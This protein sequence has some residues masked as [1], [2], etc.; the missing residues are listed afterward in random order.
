M[1]LKL[2]SDTGQDYFPVEFLSHWDKKAG[3]V[4]EDFNLPRQ[5]ERS[6]GLVELVLDRKSVV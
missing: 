1:K 3:L 5:I 2:G 6:L 4:V